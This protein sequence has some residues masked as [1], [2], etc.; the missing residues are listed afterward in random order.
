MII[1]DLIRNMNMKHTNTDN[2][3]VTARGWSGWV[4]VGKGGGDGGGGHYCYI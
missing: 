4:K 1:K 2:S 3:V